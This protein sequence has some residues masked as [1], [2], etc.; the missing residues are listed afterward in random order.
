MGT[1]KSVVNVLH[2]FLFKDFEIKLLKS[3]EIYIS[4][5]EYYARK[6]FFDR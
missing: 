6:I 5:L 3:M 2:K 1:F 4:V